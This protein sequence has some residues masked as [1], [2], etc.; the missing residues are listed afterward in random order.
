MNKITNVRNKIIVIE[1]IFKTTKIHYGDHDEIEGYDGIS[2]INVRLFDEE[3]EANKYI[4]DQ[5]V[6]YGEDADSGNTWKLI[7]MGMADEFQMVN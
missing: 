5:S 3:K 1:R 2:K 4:E 6:S 7:Y